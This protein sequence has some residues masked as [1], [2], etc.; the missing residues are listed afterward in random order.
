MVLRRSKV[1][2]FGDYYIHEADDKNPSRKDRGSVI[3]NITANVII[4]FRLSI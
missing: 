2:P 1:K 3:E 4:K